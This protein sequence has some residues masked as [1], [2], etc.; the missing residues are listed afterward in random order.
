MIKLIPD[1]FKGVTQIRVSC[2]YLFRI[3]IDDTYLLTKDEQG[4]DTFQPVGG[5]YKYLDDAIL[6][7]FNA[8]Q[9][10]RF[11]FTSDLDG[12]LRLIVPRKD[13]KKFHKWYNKEI[14]QER[15]T[16]HNLFR[17]FKE[18]LLDRIPQLNPQTFT[19]LRYKYC[20][21]HI[22]PSR[23]LND[24]QIHYADV[25]EIIFSREQLREMLALKNQESGLYRFA[26]REEIL[27]KG[28]IN[29]NQI[30]TISEHS[31]KILEDQRNR[32]YYIHKKGKIFECEFTPDKE[33]ITT[34]ELC[35]NLPDTNL[36]EP[37]TFISYNSIHKRS[38]F[39][40]C[41]NNGKILGNFWIDK[42]NVADIWSN[43]ALNALDSNNC[44]YAIIFINQQYLIRST[45]CY[46]EAKRIVDNNIRH[47]IIMLDVDADFVAKQIRSWITNDLADKDKLSTFKK[48][49]AYD[50]MTGHINN[51][52][53]NIDNQTA[54][55]QTIAN[56]D[57]K[58]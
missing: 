19:K 18:E 6:S 46:S 16:I 10:T 33:E 3:K 49:F 47:L 23:Y 30:P 27:S 7:R 51:S 31:F 40:F 58:S 28:C 56:M 26:T 36:N 32:I 48:L 44:K 9:C 38:V 14:S 50:D 52:V 20:G 15:E 45:A 5:V 13:I 29:G 34:D 8:T 37:F 53:Y 55:I 11:G 42:K 24:M 22:H 35:K 54:I 12:D 2:A 57:K 17:E 4:R 39:E 1:E 21:Q 25:V 41:C 43:D